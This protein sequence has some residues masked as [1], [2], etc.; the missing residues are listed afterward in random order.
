MWSNGIRSSPQSW[1]SSTIT[2]FATVILFGS[3]WNF[4]W[5]YFGSGLAL[6]S[7]HFAIM[8]PCIVGFPH[9]EADGEVT[10]RSGYEDP[11]T[12]MGNIH[13]SHDENFFANRSVH[14]NSVTYSHRGSRLSVTLL[15]RLKLASRAS[16]CN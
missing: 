2:I 9:L 3:G 13:T 4:I 16:S 11:F 7:P 8:I 14:L 1:L 10:P 5:Y 6:C 12:G 15:H